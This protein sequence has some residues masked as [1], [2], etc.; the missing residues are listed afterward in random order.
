MQNGLNVEKDL[1]DAL[2]RLGKGPANIISTALYI[3]SNLVS[4]NV[5]EHGSVGRTSIGL[6]RRGDYTTMDYSPQEIEILEDLRDILLMG[7]TT[8]TVVPEIQRVKFQK[9]I[10][11][12]AMSS[13]PT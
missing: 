8:L 2:M 13:L 4:P 9:N 6:Y 7:G 11:N 5:V 12:V 3:Q 1:Y 10:L